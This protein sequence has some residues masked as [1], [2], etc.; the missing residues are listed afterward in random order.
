VLP[1]GDIVTIDTTQRGWHPAVTLPHPGPWGD[2]A[3]HQPDLE[4]VS[5]EEGDTEHSRV[6]E[7]GHAWFV[8]MRS[9]VRMD[10]LLISVLLKDTF[11]EEWSTM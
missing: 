2:L 4:G 10:A 9:C 7:L 11:T 5:D 8:T 1:V 6:L 3:S